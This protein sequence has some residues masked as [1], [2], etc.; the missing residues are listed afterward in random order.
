MKR[1]A[2]VRNV[3]VGALTTGLVQ[4]AGATVGGATGA[5]QGPA[6][7]CTTTWGERGPAAGTIVGEGPP[8]DPM[9]VTVGWEPNDWPEGLREV[10]TCVSLDGQAVPAMTRLTLQPP[11]AG[12]IA[13]DL[14]LPAGPAGSLVC[15]Q[16]ILVGHKSTEG[17]KR[18]T[19]AVCF[20]LR[21]AEE[22]L[23]GPET[24]I[25]PAAPAPADPPVRIPNT[26]P[27]NPPSTPPARSQ[28]ASPPTT[29]AR[30]Q[31]AA[32]AAPSTPRPPAP[33]VQ[34]VRVAAPAPAIKAA[35]PSTRVGQAADELA[36]TPSDNNGMTAASAGL[37]TAEAPVAPD[38]AQARAALPHT[39]VS[40]Q[41]PLAA[42]GGLMALGGAGIIMGAPKRKMRRA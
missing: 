29:P 41:I 2:V 35:P 4:L 26:H 31:V 13:V 3:T 39:G 36:R 40:D 22:L 30:M 32:P 9:T 24:G 27:A 12:N 38:A 20:K 34:T 23:A 15:Q 10:V 19:H 28:T 16:S 25:E 17:R 33:A 6:D 1:K 5:D 11:N 8:G 21:A 42:A 14:V 37:S 18:Q 7:L